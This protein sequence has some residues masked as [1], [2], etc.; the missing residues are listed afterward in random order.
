MI[1]SEIPNLDFREVT[2][3]VNSKLCPVHI[4]LHTHTHTHTH[5]YTYTHTN[6]H[7]HTH[8]FTNTQ[9]HTHTHSHASTPSEHFLKSIHNVWPEKIFFHWTTM[10]IYL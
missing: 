1:E 8:T 7:I 4:Y 3:L 5:T 9:I 6:T 2:S 10:V